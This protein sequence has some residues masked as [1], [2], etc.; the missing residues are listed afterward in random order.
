[1]TLNEAKVKVAA[2]NK[3]RVDTSLGGLGDHITDATNIV[4]AAVEAKGT[5]EKPTLQEVH[6]EK[7]VTVDTNGPFTGRDFERRG[8]F[9]NPDP[10]KYKMTKAYENAGGGTTFCFEALGAGERLA[11]EAKD[12]IEKL[13]TIVENTRFRGQIISIK[14]PISQSTRPC[15]DCK[16]TGSYLL[17]THRHPCGKCKGLGRVNT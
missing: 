4:L 3:W 1:M 15:P 12:A 9:Y 17:F 16:E 11:Q 2:Y 6:K 8:S 10:G 7:T 13:H 14:D 5:E